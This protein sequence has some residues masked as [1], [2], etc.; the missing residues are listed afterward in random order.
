[1][2]DQSYTLDLALLESQVIENHISNMFLDHSLNHTTLS[3]NDPLK[4]AF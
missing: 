2:F 3:F 4:G 1:M